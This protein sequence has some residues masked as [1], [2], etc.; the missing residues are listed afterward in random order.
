M[1]TGIRA[2]ALPAVVT[3]TMLLVTLAAGGCSDG[4][5]PATSPE[6]LGLQ[7]IAVEAPDFTLE[8]MEDEQVT[9]SSL[10]G[11]PVLLNFWALKCPPCRDEMPFLDAAAAKYN[12][13]AIVMAIDIGD[14]ASSVQDYFGDAQLSMIVPL[15][16]QGLAA[17]S[18]SVGFTPT[19]FLIDSQG[20]V[21]YVKVGPFAN[22]N[23]VIT[24][25]ELIVP[26]A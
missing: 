8:T 25:M 20:I 10:R 9:L 19:T 3:A 5:T 13:Q 6:D 23:E 17:S 14:S 15:D 12:G 2:A 24:A 16:V 26:E 21:R 1:N 22:A 4:S 7:E 11:T 18:Y